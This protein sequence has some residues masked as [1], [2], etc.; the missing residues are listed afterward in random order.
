MKEGPFKKGQAAVNK[1]SRSDSPIRTL[2]SRTS[3]L[4]TWCCFQSSLGFSFKINS[5]RWCWCNREGLPSYYR[6]I[7]LETMMEGTFLTHNSNSVWSGC[8]P[9]WISL[10]LTTK[11]RVFWKIGHRSPWFQ[12]S[13][14]KRQNPLVFRVVCGLEESHLSSYLK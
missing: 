9:I 4:P 13:I 6:A 7:V 12:F 11:L 14:Q 1:S 5:F 8:L 10:Y 3:M 2:E